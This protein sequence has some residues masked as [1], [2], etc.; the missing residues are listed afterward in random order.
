[1]QN[2]LHFFYNNYL[3]NLSK[4]RFF[5]EQQYQ[6]LLDH[7]AGFYKRDNEY[8]SFACSV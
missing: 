6:T 2:G 7:F 3:F 1:M 4:R 5:Y 8:S